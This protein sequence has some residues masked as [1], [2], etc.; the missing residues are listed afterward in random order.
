MPSESELLAQ[1]SRLIHRLANRYADSGVDHDD[2]VQEGYLGALRAIRTH[3]PACGRTLT[4]WIAH[5]ARQ[6]MID[7]VRVSRRAQ[8][9]AQLHDQ[10]DLLA[11]RAEDDPADGDLWEALWVMRHHMSQ[12]QSRVF[13][14]WLGVRGRRLAMTTLAKKYGIGLQ[15]VGQIIAY[16][17]E[18]CRRHL[19]IDCELRTVRTAHRR[20]K[21][22][23]VN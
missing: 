23:L 15:K 17:L 6:R 3:D 22:K 20:P 12:L 19:G 21:L 13:F 16:G 4:S 11:D 7:L 8:R 1:H 5:Q 2:L 10:T 14:G 9:P 18:L